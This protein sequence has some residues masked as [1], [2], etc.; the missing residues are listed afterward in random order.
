VYR[1]PRAGAYQQITTFGD[2]ASIV[3]LLAEAPA[4][5]VSA[6]LG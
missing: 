1:E 5:D 2:G 3:P 6:L 4:V